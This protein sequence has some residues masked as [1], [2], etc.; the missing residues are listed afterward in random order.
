M[1]RREIRL[2]DASGAPSGDADTV[3]REWRQDTGAALLRP[4]VRQA[5]GSLRLDAQIA[6]PGIYLYPNPDGTMRRELVSRRLLSDLAS[7]ETLKLRAITLEHPDPARYP[8][9]VTPD[10]VA[11]LSVGTTGQEVE[12]QDGRPV[13][14]GVVNARRALDWIERRQAAGLPIEV[15]PGYFVTMAGRG[16]VDPEFG[17]FDDEQIGRDYNHLALTERGRGGPT[18]RARVDS[19]GFRLD[20]N[21][22][23]SDPTMLEALIALGYS[24]QDAARI[25]A[26]FDSLGSAGV[27]ARLDA[28]PA[29]LKKKLEDAKA[30]V[31]ELTKELEESKKSKGDSVALDQVPALVDELVALREVAARFD[32]IK[33]ED[34]AKLDADGVRLAICTAAGIEVPESM[35]EDAEL[36]RVYRQARIDSLPK[37]AAEGQDRRLDGLRLPTERAPD[38]R[39]DAADHDPDAARFDS[40]GSY[41]KTEG[42]DAGDK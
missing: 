5:D 16:G 26:R 15:S 35:R 32:S 14:H 29:D 25:V 19:T 39:Q 11:T 42:D 10:N 7:L 24:R 8:D 36:S 21:P 2:D 17:P 33:A 41:G 30:K 23:T 20:S 1:R 6:E 4:P 40:F 38:T 22:P 3:V 37:T 9:L 27:L 31:D 18:A 34:L 12:I 28:D 13:F